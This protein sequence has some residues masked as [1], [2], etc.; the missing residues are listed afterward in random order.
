MKDKQ[1]ISSVFGAWKL[2]SI[3][4]QHKLLWAIVLQAAIS[5]ANFVLLM[6]EDMGIFSGEIVGFLNTL[7]RAVGIFAVIILIYRAHHEIRAR[8][9]FRDY[10]REVGA[11]NERWSGEDG[12][13][14]GIN[15][16]ISTAALGNLGQL[17]LV[18]L[19]DDMKL[20]ETILIVILILMSPFC[21]YKVSQ[22]YILME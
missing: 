3:S 12:S 16:Y 8:Y 11:L 13:E 19:F 9:L 5:V 7:I 14:L 1:G 21:A 2:L 10:P 22:K 20:I 18:Y 4:T 6:M 17:V 15:L